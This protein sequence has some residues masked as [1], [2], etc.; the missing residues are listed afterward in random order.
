MSDLPNP[1]FAPRRNDLP[2]L[3]RRRVKPGLL[4]SGPAHTPDGHIDVVHHDAKRRV[5]PPKAA[6]TPAPTPTHRPS[7][8]PVLTPRSTPA[9]KSTPA[10]TT[11]PRPTTPAPAPQ[12]AAAS[13]SLDLSAPAPPASTPPAAPPPAAPPASSSTSLDLD[14]GSS[15]TPTPARTPT[16]ASTTSLDLGAGTA[17]PAP[18]SSTSLDLGLGGAPAP[19]PAAGQASSASTSLDLGAGPQPTAG[20][21]R[22]PTPKPPPPAERHHVLRRTR[23][24]VTTLLD[25][26]NPV[27]TLRPVQSG[28]GELT[29]DAVVGDEVGDLRI[30][31]AWALTDGRTGTV[32]LEAERRHGPD[33]RRPLVWAERQGRFDRIAL[34]LRQARSLARLLV[35]GFSPSKR[36]L[37][38][39][40][41][42]VI[43]TYGGDRIDAPIVSAPSPA[44]M[45]LVSV[46]NVGGEFV[47]RSEMDPVSGSVRDTCR[48]FGYDRITWL[49]D[50]TP[51][52]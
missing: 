13:N 44:V 19:P 30:G 42:V 48:A 40:G 12:P 25:F 29:V 23:P 14:L 35:Y 34:D 10:P 36:S 31:A 7:P 37:T 15:P 3:R 32:E 16:P 26:G 41:T 27:V 8:A 28:I 47:V 4:E 52:A 51:V 5:D 2:W 22:A 18:A 6:P 45:A 46:Y 21:G 1:K 39:G 17:P 20:P 33:D 24:G 11:P 49:D 38:W 50:H 43:T 9:P